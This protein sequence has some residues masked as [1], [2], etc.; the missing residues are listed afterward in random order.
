MKFHGIEMKG[1]LVVEPV[2]SLP[3]TNTPYRFIYNKSDDTLYY[4]DGS[5]W[6]QITDEMN[7]YTGMVW[8]I[9]SSNTTMVVN[10]GYMADT[11]SS[12]LTL[13]FPSNPSTGDKVAVKD[14][15]ENSSNNNIVLNR[16]GNN[17]EGN[18]SNF[19]VSI[20]GNGIL[21]IYTDS[22]T[23]WVRVYEAYGPA[24]FA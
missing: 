7:E 10:N 16:N 11:S 24:T 14:F 6:I 1:P 2:A 19:T 9:V 15:K 8:N 5:G 18:S 21:F 3:S 22:S 4:N 23:G 12:S 17:I 20:D 13:S